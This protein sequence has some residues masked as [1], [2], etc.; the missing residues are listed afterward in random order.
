[1]EGKTDFTSKNYQPYEI[2]AFKSGEEFIKYLNS[3]SIKNSLTK[4]Y[5]KDR[6]K[7]IIDWFKPRVDTYGDWIRAN[8]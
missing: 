2:K 7:S 1:M 5:G 4:L 8:I 6:Y 3:E